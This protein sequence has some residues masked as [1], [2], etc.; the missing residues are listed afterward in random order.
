MNLP[1]KS[2]RYQTARCEAEPVVKTARELPYAAPLQ[3]LL[4]QAKGHS[5]CTRGLSMKG[6]GMD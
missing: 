4:C 1:A 3:Q 5:V 6:N 2:Y